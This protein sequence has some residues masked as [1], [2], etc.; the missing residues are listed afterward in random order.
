MKRP[1]VLLTDFG[2]RDPYVGIMKCVIEGIAP[3]ARVIDLVHDLPPQDV[4]AASVALAMAAPYVPK[5]AIVVTVVD[6]GVGT[7]RRILAAETQSAIFLAPDNGVL[8]LALRARPPRC[9]RA[10]ERRELF[11]ASVSATF[12]GRD[13]FA[14]VAARLAR[15]LPPARLGRVVDDRV[16]LP[17]GEPTREESRMRGEILMIDRYGNAITN[18]PGAWVRRGQEVCVRGKRIARVQGAYGDVAPKQTLALVGSMDTLEIAI[19]QGNAAE[20]SRLTPG[21]EVEVRAER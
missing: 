19:N 14:P 10:V 11:L 13:V 2:H 9:V 1:I 16:E 5:G 15:G 18:I 8:T 7:R 21:L 20:V 17:I 3:G 12:H 4:R 6:P